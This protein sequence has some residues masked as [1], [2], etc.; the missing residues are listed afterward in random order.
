MHEGRM[1]EQRRTTRLGNARA[2]GSCGPDGLSGR[3]PAR[4]G[5]HEDPARLLRGAQNGRSPLLRAGGQDRHRRAPLR[6]VRQPGSRR[7]VFC[8]PPGAGRLG[9]LHRRAHR[10]PAENGQGL[11]RGAAV[12]FR[13][14]RP[15]GHGPDRG[16]H[17]KEPGGLCGPGSRRRSR[18]R[19]AGTGSVQSR[20]RRRCPGRDSRRP[21]PSRSRASCGAR[22]SSPGIGNAYSDEI[23]HAARMSPFAIAKSLDRD[24]RSSGSTTPSTAFWEQRWGKP[25]G[26]PPSELKDTKRSHMR[27]HGRTGE[28]CPVCGDT[29]REVSFADTALQYCPTLPDAGKDPG[30][31]PDVALPEIADHRG[32][33]GEHRGADVSG[34]QKTPPFLHQEWRG[35]CCWS[36]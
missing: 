17:E 12:V 34:K 3:A 32:P 8:L 4:S 30:R 29:V 5:G 11:H 20:V 10:T 21:V 23:L 9:P 13:R 19:R 6:Q 1:T 31:P 15:A 22:A 2:S 25:A 16:R 28:A 35:I 26:K 24:G 7:A 18:H 27:V 33:S 36:G 14:L